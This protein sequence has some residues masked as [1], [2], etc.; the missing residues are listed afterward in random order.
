MT[1]TAAMVKELREATGAAVLDCK[2]ALS[3]TDGDVEKA[4]AILE[5]K[6]LATARKKAGREAHEGKV[7][8]YTHHGGRVGVI[9]EV[10][11]ETDFVANTDLFQEFVHDLALHIAFAAPQYLAREDVPQELVETQSAVYRREAEASGKPENVIERIVE[12]RM[13]KF[14]EDICL[15]EQPFIRDEDIKI[16]DLVVRMVAELKENIVVR[17][18]ARFE[19]GEN[20]SGNG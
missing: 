4:K 13:S 1:I 2:N 20:S 9:L 16:G 6:G 19:L 3:E 8:T 18:V 11:C 14:Y 17:R 7:E 12:G 5:E 10:N 15:L